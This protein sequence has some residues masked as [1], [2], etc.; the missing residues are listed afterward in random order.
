MCATPP[1]LERFEA[2]G[3]FV[4]RGAL[5]EGQ[6][7][8]LNQ[9]LSTLIGELGAAHA[10]GERACDFWRQLARSTAAN[11]I[12]WHPGTASFDEQ[13]VM[14]VG[15]V[16]HLDARFEQ[17]IR[18]PV[19]RTLGSLLRPP[20]AVIQTAVIYKQPH[21][22]VVQ[23]GYHRD[24]EYLTVVPSSA[25]ALAFVALDDCDEDNGALRIV[26]KS[27]RLGPGLRLRLGVD[28]F[29]RVSGTQHRFG[30]S[31]GTLLEMRRGDAAFVRGDTYHASAPNQSARPRRA[32]I[33]HALG[34]DGALRD[35]WVEK[36]P[37][38]FA[39]I[40]DRGP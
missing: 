5:D 32:L 7:A 18:T 17:V 22:D 25:L 35:S 14:R 39:P 19:V 38:G 6:C 21:S 13:H 40:P 10:R 12:F 3:F 27:H 31:E 4:R 29:E 30:P 33:V 16:L 37:G 15:H 9:K 23:F 2:D 20:A 26:P 11:E 1:E 28:G 34:G 24:A 36:P 8:T